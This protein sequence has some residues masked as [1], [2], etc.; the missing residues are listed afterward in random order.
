MD[1]VTYD[2]FRRNLK[3]YVQK[4]NDDADSLIVTTNEPNNFVVVMSKDNDI[5]EMYI[6][7]LN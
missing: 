1:T 3:T 4:V 5:G 7:N 6:L 2:T